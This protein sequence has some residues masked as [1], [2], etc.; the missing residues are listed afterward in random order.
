ML[1]E[2]GMEALCYSP[3]PRGV[4]VLVEVGVDVLRLLGPN[5]PSRP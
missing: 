5:D 1:V 3:R 2:R 4:V